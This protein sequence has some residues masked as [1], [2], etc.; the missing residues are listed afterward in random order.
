MEARQ[1][2]NCFEQYLSYS[3]Y[4]ESFVLYLSTY[5]LDN[6]RDFKYD[7]LKYV[8]RQR[9][10]KFLEISKKYHVLIYSKFRFMKVGIRE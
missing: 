3:L 7:D 8:T 10:P 5:C 9:Y 2:F 6:L 1:F 4:F